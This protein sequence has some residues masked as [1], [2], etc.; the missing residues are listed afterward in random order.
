MFFIHTVV[1][2]K[3]SGHYNTYTYANKNCNFIE[4]D[5]LLYIGFDLE[6]HKKYEY[7]D[8]CH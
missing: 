6:N 4:N 7:K 8:K 3:H 2:V 1:Y 5:I